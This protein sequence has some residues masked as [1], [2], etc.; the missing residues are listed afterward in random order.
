MKW[1]SDGSFWKWSVHKLGK[2][3]GAVV[4]YRF[5]GRDLADLVRYKNEI[6]VSFGCWPDGFG[7]T[8]APQECGAWRI[9]SCTFWH[10]YPVCTSLSTF[11]LTHIALELRI[12]YTYPHMLLWHTSAQYE[13]LLLLP[14]WITTFN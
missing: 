6:T 10:L 4:K 9:L 2:Q 8:V 5:Y 7:F 1:V 3:E 14:V 13:I 12:M 11:T